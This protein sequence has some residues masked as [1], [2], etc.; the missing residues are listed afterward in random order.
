MGVEASQTFFIQVGK[1][2]QFCI[3][4]FYGTQSLKQGYIAFLL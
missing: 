4:V 2:L 1:F 3:E